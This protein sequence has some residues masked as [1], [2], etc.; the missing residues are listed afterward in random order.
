MATRTQQAC[1]RGTR[2]LAGLPTTLVVIVFVALDMGVTIG[3]VTNGLG[4][5]ADPLFRPITQ[6][7]VLPMLL[8]FFVYLGLVFIVFTWAP[9]WVQAI[10]AGFLIT[11]HLMGFLSWLRMHALPQLQILYTNIEYRVGI[12][13]GVAALTTLLAYVDLSTCPG[14]P[15]SGLVRGR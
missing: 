1:R 15:G 13:A 7:G 12:P 6:L 4:V 14:I 2:T 3:G 9:P 11:I 10:I 8:T 5:E